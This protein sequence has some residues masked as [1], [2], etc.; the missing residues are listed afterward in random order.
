MIKYISILL[1]LITFFCLCTPANCSVPYTRIK[2]DKA[3]VALTFDDGPHPIYTEKILDILKSYNVR[4]TFFVIGSNA[5]K[6][7]SLICR[8]LSDGH[9][10]ENHTFSHKYLNRSGE[11]EI[12]YELEQGEESL[13]TIANCKFHYIRPPGGLYNSEFKRVADEMSCGIVLW[14]VDTRDWS[15]PGV[16]SVVNTVLNNVKRGDI[17]LMHDFVSG[18]S[19]T[20]EA[21]NII[22][23]KL[24][25]EGYRFVTVSELIALSDSN[26]E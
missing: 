20:P 3:L 14:S 2:T 12:L 8:E 1:S 17:I 9:E 18:K 5:E 19:Q 15:R 26:D 4:A 16:S 13:R 10:V 6:Y 23:P 7:P 21:L 11:D 25:S 24:L 22:I